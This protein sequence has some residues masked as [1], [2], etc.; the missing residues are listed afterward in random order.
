[1]KQSIM[2]KSLLLSLVLC[3]NL[4]THAQAT[5]LVVDCQ[6]PGWLSS[7]I[8][9]GDQQ[10]VKN[11]KVTGYINDED[12]R[13]IGRLTQLNL[14]VVDLGEANILGN[15]WCGAF[16][17]NK[18]WS[19]KTG[20]WY[21]TEYDYD[22]HLQKLILPKSLEAYIEEE[23]TSEKQEVDTL[24]FDTQITSIENVFRRKIGHIQL[25]ENIDSIKV[26][27]GR[28]LISAYLP[29]TLKYLN[30]GFTNALTDIS[31]TNISEFPSLEYMGNLC[32][33]ND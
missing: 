16:K 14:N 32:F 7:K 33:V 23:F 21:I 22:Y 1:M 18:E 29:S 26:T 11:L 5:D 10:T 20:Y 12:L 31:Q 8:N 13:F 9:Y 24:V 17:H 28:N 6:T 15:S 2:K 27:L 19:R 3:I 25:G 30:G 4:C